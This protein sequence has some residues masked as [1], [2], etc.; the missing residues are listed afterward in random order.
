L[1]KGA[2]DSRNPEIVTKNF[3][4]RLFFAKFMP[5]PLW[6][7]NL[8]LQKDD[9]LSYAHELELVG[10]AKSIGTSPKDDESKTSLS[11]RL[12]FRVLA[13]NTRLFHSKPRWFGSK[14]TVTEKEIGDANFAHKFEVTG[15]PSGVVTSGL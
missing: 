10:I 4:H 2:Y 15:V 6:Q 11:C 13:A 1:V 8:I 3:T 12:E 9:A 7:T 14:R 5:V